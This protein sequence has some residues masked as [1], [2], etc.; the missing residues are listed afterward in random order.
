[1]VDHSCNEDCFAEC[2]AIESLREMAE[3]QNAE[4]VSPTEQKEK[5]G[6]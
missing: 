6:K 5:E 2:W 3:S 1:M 4:K